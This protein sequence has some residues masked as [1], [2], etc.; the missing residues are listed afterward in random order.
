MLVLASPFV[1]CSSSLLAFCLC[2]SLICLCIFPWHHPIPSYLTFICFILFSPI[3]LVITTCH[4]L[5]LSFYL[6]PSFSFL[7]PSNS[8]LPLKLCLY[9][10]S[11]QWNGWL[12]CSEK[13]TWCILWHFLNRSVVDF[14]CGV[15]FCY[16]AKWCLY[17]HKHSFYILSHHGLSR[18]IEYS[19]LCYDLVI[20]PSSASFDLDFPRM[21]YKQLFH[22]QASSLSWYGACAPQ[23]CF[24]LWFHISCTVNI[25]PRSSQFFHCNVVGDAHRTCYKRKQ[26]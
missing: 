20:C 5:P 15:N 10:P 11:T 1:N 24:S 26:T 7:F 25:M 16:A 19:S 2:V 6:S 21:I 18:D 13:D 22:V 14:Q 4:D 3:N 8:T 12:Y 23:H 17:I 9:S